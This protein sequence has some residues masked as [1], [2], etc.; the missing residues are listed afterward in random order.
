MITKPTLAQVILMNNPYEDKPEEPKI[1]DVGLWDRLVYRKR[2]QGGLTFCCTG[3]MGGG[4]TSLLFTIAQILL[5]RNKPREK[6]FWRGTFACEFSKF[7]PNKIL[8]HKNIYPLDVY[9]NNASADYPQT[10][11]DSFAELYEKAEYGTLNIVYANDEIKFWTGFICWL[12]EHNNGWTS[13]F[14]DEIEDICP[15]NSLGE[16]WH[17]VNQFGAAAKESRKQGV[18]IYSSSQ[19]PGDIDW[20]FLR[21]C[22]VFG[23]LQGSRRIRPCPV[24][25]SAINK[26][27]IGEA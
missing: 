21:K 18:S 26:L 24:Y 12:L 6:L 10:L 3:I 22:M 14:L 19:N 17:L 11:F 13:L 15:N 27:K 1:I 2:N 20:K 9:E 8:V 5:K 7:E 25:Q 16:T 23:Y 4:K